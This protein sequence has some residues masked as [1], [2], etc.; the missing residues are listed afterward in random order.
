MRQGTA[1]VIAVF[2][3]FACGH[4]VERAGAVGVEVQA[5]LREDGSGSL[6]VGNPEEAHWSWEACSPDLSSCRPFGR[7]WEISTA[8]VAAETVFRV[9]GAG[10]TGLSPLWRGNLAVLAPP[11]VRGPLRAN[12]LV[13]PVPA[14]W[15]GGWDG[16]F[17]QTQLSVCARPTGGP[18]IA[19]TEPKNP[20]PPCPDEAAVL[21][22]AFAGRYLRIADRR[23]SL[24]TG[25]TY[26][27][28][29]PFHRS[30]W[31]SDGQTAVAMLGRIAAANGPRTAG[32]G[33]GPLRLASISKRGVAQVR[34][35]L[36]C[37][38]VV[39]GRRDGFV[40]RVA[41]WASPRGPFGPAAVLE[42]STRLAQRLGE[43]RVRMTVEVDGRRAA[44]R[45][46]VLLDRQRR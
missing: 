7:G 13:T 11:S 25:F 23:F 1:L 30:L 8:G 24:D 34:C 37:R 36:G 10:K 31:A 12:E 26:E 21:D 18:C 16:D 28:V 19:I 22:P 5:L 3:L 20:N 40:A 41:R 2:T 42:L 33:P 29:F 9:S 44:R 43:G 46:V 32:C 38:A 27:G 15:D 17:D 35:P 4:D 45:T 6:L 39:I 14:S